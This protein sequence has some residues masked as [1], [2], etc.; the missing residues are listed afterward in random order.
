MSN[1][2]NAY[3]P[4]PRCSP[5]SGAG[6]LGAVNPGLPLVTR[7]YSGTAPTGPK[8]WY[9][10]QSGV[11]AAVL[12]NEGARRPLLPPLGKGRVGVGLTRSQIAFGNARAREVALR[13]LGPC[14]RQGE[15]KL[16]RQV[17]SQVKLGNEGR[18]AG[19][20]RPC[21]RTPATRAGATSPGPC[22]GG[23]SM[24]SAKAKTAH[25]TTAGPL[26]GPAGGIVTGW[27]W[28]VSGGCPP[29]LSA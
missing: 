20:A 18:N 26:N 15:A 5:L 17:R 23:G 29:H 8:A 9:S 27:F 14:T 2:V 28:R 3:A 6:R 24:A 13:H 4:S 12:H 19:C 7:G 16:R 1:K 21:R 25:K 22:P 10:S 11:V